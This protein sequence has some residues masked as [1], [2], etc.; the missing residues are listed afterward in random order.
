MPVLLNVAASDVDGTLTVADWRG[1]GRGP[2][3]TRRL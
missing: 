2:A 1:H 3:L